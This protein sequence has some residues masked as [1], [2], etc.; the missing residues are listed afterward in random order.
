MVLWHTNNGAK[1]CFIDYMVYPGRNT[2][3]LSGTEVVKI[4]LGNY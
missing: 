4:L 1:F 2:E 3:S